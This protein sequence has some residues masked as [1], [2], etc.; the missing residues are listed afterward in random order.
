MSRPA[1]GIVAAGFLA[2]GLVL[3]FTSDPGPDELAWGGVLIRS[4]AL[5]GA[6][7][8]VLPR[9]RRV[10]PA[11]WVAVLVVVAVLAVRPRLFLWGLVAAVVGM[12]LTRFG[13]AR[14]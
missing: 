5:L 8:L 2:V 9:A 6:W 11:T 4:G 3:T 10:R 14:S 13:R 12:V 1:L 7:W